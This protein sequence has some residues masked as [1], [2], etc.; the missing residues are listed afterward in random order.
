MTIEIFDD[1]FARSC[2]CGCVRFNLLKSGAIECDNCQQKQ[3]N[4]KWNEAMNPE[5]T[6]EYN[7]EKKVDF[8][9]TQISQAQDVIRMAIEKNQQCFWPEIVRQNNGELPINAILEASRQMQ[10][11][12][13]I[14]LRE[15]SLEHAME[16]LLIQ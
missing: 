6:T 14:R 9:A 4:L 7:P 13:Q 5:Y 3:P 12:N 15:D 16:Y 11:N 2:Q 10:R 1:H 8:T